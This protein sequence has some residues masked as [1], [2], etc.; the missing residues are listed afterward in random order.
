MRN[1]DKVIELNLNPNKLAYYPMIGMHSPGEAVQILNKP[2]WE[3]KD[4]EPD[5]SSL[6][7]Y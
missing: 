7:L 6:D 5:V 4:A 1:G 2:L 3:V